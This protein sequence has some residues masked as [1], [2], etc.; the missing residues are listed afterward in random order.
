[1]GRTSKFAGADANLEVRAT[2][3]DEVARWITITGARQNNLR[4]LDVDLP[5]GRFIC[6]TGVSGSGKSSLVTDTLYPALA[7]DLMHAEMEPGAYE[8]LDGLGHLDKVIMIDQD[9]IGRTPRSNPATYTGVLTHIRDLYAKLPESERRGYKPG[10]FSFNVAEGRCSACEGHGAVRLESDFMADVWVTCEVCEGRRF[11]RETLDIMFKQ[12]TIAEVLEM[13]VG[14]ALEHFRNQPKIAAILQTLVDVGLGYIRLGQPATTI[15]GGEAQRVKLAKELSRPKTGKTL[16]I[17]D[18][19]TTGLHFHDVEM[20]LRVLHRFVDEGNTVLVVEHHPDVIKTAD[21]LIDM[22]PEGGAGGGMIVAQGTP[23]EVAET[24]TPTAEMLREVLSEMPRG[25]ER[26]ARAL[27]ARASGTAAPTRKKSHLVVRGAREHNLKNVEVAIPRRKLTVISGVSG[28]GKTSLA[29]DTLYAE[30]QRR[31]VESLSSYARQFVDQMQ[32]PKVDRIAGLPP[33][34]AIDQTGRGYSPRSTVGTTTEIYDY[35]RV[36]FARL[37]QPHC[38]ECDA[39][40]GAQTVS[41]IVDTILEAHEGEHVLL[42]APLAPEANQEYA[43]M[44]DRAQRNGWQR[45]RVDGEVHRL[46]FEGKLNRRRKHVIEVVVDRITVSTRNRSRLAEAVEAAFRMSDESVVVAEARPFNSR[47]LHDG[48]SERRFSKLNSCTACG[49]SYEPITPRSFSFNHY[50]GWCPHCYGLGTAW[51]GESECPFCHGARV[52]PEAAAVRLRGCTIMDL[53]RLPLGDGLHF[54]ENLHL[55][56]RERPKA[57]EILHEIRQRLGFLVRVGLDY[58]SLDR[59]A[60]TLAGGEAQRVKLAGQLGSGLTGVMYVL[61]E[62][63]VGVHPADNDLMLAALKTLRD[64]GNTLVVVEH[65]PQ[66]YAEADHIIDIG[67]GAGPNGGHVVASGTPA[68]VARSRNSVTG[69]FLAGKLKIEVPQTRRLLPPPPMAAP[70]CW[71]TIDGAREHNL[72]NLTVPIPLGVL[73]CVTGPSGSGK[74]T[75]IDDTLFRALAASLG[76]EETHGKPGE[77]G[78]LLGIENID[79]VINIDQAP[80]GGTPRSNPASYI[81][82]FDIIRELYAKLPESKLRGFKAGRFSFNMKGGRC[83]KCEGMGSRCVQMHFLPDVW[84]KCEECDGL[85]YNPETLQVKYRG[86][87]IA[88]VLQMSIEEARELF[89]A[90]PRLARRLQ[91]LCDVGLGYVPMGQSAPTLSG[92]EAQRVKLASELARPVRDHTLYLLDEP[93]TG[94]HVADVKQL[95][96][97]L[98]RLVDAGHTVVVIEHNLDVIKSADYVVD[99]GPTGGEKGGYLIAAGTPEEVAA[100]EKSV[101]APYL[102]GALEE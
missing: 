20:L 81:G 99:L 11:D 98:N 25:R 36:L 10:R 91:V 41:Q 37:G 86:K 49:A 74:S 54:F 67:P 24:D 64:E 101:T 2:R 23:E 96:G 13:E 63:S 43:D 78:E 82:A 90:V 52:R 60:P 84:V 27:S 59:T 94:L 77:H 47:P 5:L 33:S 21:Y 15:S 18:E 66:T 87:S 39:E 62:P 30:G 58:L 35:L 92:G 93:T 12:K 85:R 45:V 76:N 44:L 48:E 26:P 100:C 8:K 46:P 34:I 57:A 50:R 42:C 28:S 95:L 1:V 56:P 75:L 19:P 3:E 71:L 88:E 70:D 72:K 9:P 14:D 22:G 38:P 31:F 102:R 6:V 53:C 97:V 61:D 51:G 7:R 73:T 29:L 40:V 89:S 55:E 16:Y 80:I 32:K 68:Q 69:Q 79:K 83:E 17:L 65:D 4:N